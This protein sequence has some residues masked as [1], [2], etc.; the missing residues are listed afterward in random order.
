MLT[1]HWRNLRAHGPSPLVRIVH[2]S[3]SSPAQVDLQYPSVKDWPHAPLVPTPMP[4]PTAA[5]A[6][7]AAAAALTRP[8]E[9]GPPEP[10]SNAQGVGAVRGVGSPPGT[11]GR[12]GAA[13]ISTGVA[14]QV[15]AELAATDDAGTPTAVAQPGGSP[16]AAAAATRPSFAE[17]LQVRHSES[18]TF[19]CFLTCALQ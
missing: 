6:A 2:A 8:S 9:A 16:V 1:L 11:P 17:V 12:A 18:A 10:A 5:A 15:A 13:A 4:H 3:R 14:R 7:A 19:F